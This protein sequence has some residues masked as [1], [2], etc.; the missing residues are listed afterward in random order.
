MSKIFF[1]AGSVV[2][3]FLVEFMMFNWFSTRW[4]PNLMIVL[5]VFFNL[6][7]GIRYAIFAAVFGG[8]LQDAFGLQIFGINLLT[9]VVCAYLTTA[10]KP[11]LYQSGSNSSRVAFVGVVLTADF[12]LRYLLS[13]KNGGPDFFPAFRYI[14]VPQMLLTLLITVGLF[15]QLRRCVLRYF[16]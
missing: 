16:A 5:I 9:L 4:V 8:L 14:F 12:L 13:L 7:F 1:I 2:L 10:L 11:Y 3:A 6:A 15:K